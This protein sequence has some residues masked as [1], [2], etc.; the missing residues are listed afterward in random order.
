MKQKL[1]VLAL[2]GLVLSG[3]A[4]VTRGT[5]EEVR[6]VVDPP[7][8]QVETDIGLTCSG[9]PCNLQVSRKTEFTVTASKP[10]YKPESVR[11]LTDFS[12]GG[13]VGLAGNAII[14]GV[15]GVGVDALSGATLNHAPNPVLIALDPLDPDN[16]ETPPGDHLKLEEQEFR[17]KNRAAGAKPVS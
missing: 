14:G 10:G 16:K 17:R 1:A 13:A 15:I 4:T 5:T 8:A 6:V 12:G 7:D 3:C 11:V 2:L 9:M